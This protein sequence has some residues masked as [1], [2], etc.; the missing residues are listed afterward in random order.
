MSSALR[1][2]VKDLLAHPLLVGPDGVPPGATEQ[3]TQAIEQRYG[4]PLP[5]TLRDWF[6]L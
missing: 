1:Q 6:A 4:V 2:E 5:P 3:D